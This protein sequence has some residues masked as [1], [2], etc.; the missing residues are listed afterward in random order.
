MNLG[1]Q[2][3]EWGLAGDLLP[4]PWAWH[5]LALEHGCTWVL[6]HLH[7]DRERDA[8]RGTVGLG[9]WA[10]ASAAILSHPYRRRWWAA[11][12]H[13]PLHIRALWGEHPPP[14]T[15]HPEFWSRTACIQPKGLSSNRQD[16]GRVAPHPCHLHIN[17]FHPSC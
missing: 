15:L 5:S 12:P 3:P 16:P 11:L 17:T 4:P 7:S 13:L 10:V 6:G 2:Q 9:L 1:G 8:R 14:R